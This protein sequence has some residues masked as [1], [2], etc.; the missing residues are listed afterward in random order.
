MKP[1]SPATAVRSPP[2]SRS[3]IRRGQP[4]NISAPTMTKKPSTNR[5]TGEE[6]PWALN[7]LPATDIIKAPSTRPMISG[8]MYCTMAA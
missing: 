8:R 3:T 4:K 2:P 1:T 7:S 5:V 6:P